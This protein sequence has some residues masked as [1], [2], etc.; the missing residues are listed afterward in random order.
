MLAFDHCPRVRGQRRVDGLPESFERVLK[1]RLAAIGD[2]K[3]IVG[4]RRSD[5]RTAIRAAQPADF[6]LQFEAI[7]IR[8]LTDFVGD[9]PKTGI[10]RDSGGQ[11]E[12]CGTLLQNVN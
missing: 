1:A 2:R 9:L 3:R 7:L 12:D 6:G 10:V 8:L 5:C 11:P 4:R